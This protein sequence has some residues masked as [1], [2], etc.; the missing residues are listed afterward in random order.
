MVLADRK[1]QSNG[2]R[3]EE[4]KLTESVI[5]REAIDRLSKS[6]ERG[7]NI[8]R[9]EKETT[10]QGKRRQGNGS[11]LCKRPSQY[12]ESTRLRN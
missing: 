9:E 8:E 7:G 10:E 12:I 3:R 1:S 4:E 6:V 11:P 5:T 2:F